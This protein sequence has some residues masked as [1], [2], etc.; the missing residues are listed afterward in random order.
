[1]IEKEHFS[2]AVKEAF[3]ETTTSKITHT[4]LTKYQIYKRQLFASIFLKKEKPVTDFFK[5]SLNKGTY[6]SRLLDKEIDLHKHASIKFRP[7]VELE[8]YIVNIL[9]RKALLSQGCSVVT[10]NQYIYI[11]IELVI[12]YSR[13]YSLTRNEQIVTPETL[14]KSLKLVDQ[15]YI[16][17]TGFI[18]ML[19]GSL[20]AYTIKLLN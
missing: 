18:N 17:D 5:L 9:T 6:Y 12:W 8:E 3:K 19:Q 20:V 2:K 11:I 1:M 7:A 10:L 15:Y 16:A 4:R 13:A 14:L